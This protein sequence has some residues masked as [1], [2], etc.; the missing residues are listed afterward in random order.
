MIKQASGKPATSRTTA[1]CDEARCLLDA[2]G[3]AI[4]DLVQL[5]ELQFLAIVDGDSDA[6]RFDL[7][8]HEANEKKQD[9][10]YAYLSHL[11]AR[12]HQTDET[13]DS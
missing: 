13:Y 8:I 2:F 11:Q 5:H 6:G 1:Y 3:Q 10:K 9:A 7:L 4:K 12:E